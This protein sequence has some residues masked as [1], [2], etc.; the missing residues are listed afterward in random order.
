MGTFM[1][2]TTGVRLTLKF[3]FAQQIRGA[4]WSESYDLAFADLPTAIASLSNIQAFMADRVNC[5][6]VGPLLVSASLIAYA[7]PPTPG[8]PPVRR[9]SAAIGVPVFP[10]PGNAYNKAFNPT[11]PVYTADFAPTAYYISLQTNLSTSPVYSRNV[12]IAGLPDLADETSTNQIIDAATLAAMNKFLGDLNNTNN[13][14]GGK[15]GVSIRSVDRTNGNPIKAATAWNLL[16]N[17]YTVPAHGFVVGQ[18]VVAEGCKTTLG[19]FAPRGRYLIGTVPDVNTISLQAAAPPTAP[20]KLGGFRA[21]VF[22]FNAVAVATGK[23]FTKRDRG[24]P[25][26]LLVGRRRVPTIKRA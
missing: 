7:Q 19:G 24:R 5:L 22:T 3:N 20:T 9:Q 8:S 16:A 18:P 26:G 10:L 4:G 17:T 6:G 23:G 21:A 13:T 15:C 25:S 11:T 2:A 12:W 1:A 14:L